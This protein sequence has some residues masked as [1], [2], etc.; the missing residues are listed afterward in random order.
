M[1][2]FNVEAM[3]HM[4]ANITTKLMRVWS[5]ST[6]LGVSSLCTLII[7]CDNIRATYHTF[8]LAFH[9]RTNVKVDYDFI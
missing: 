8:N 1:S 9:A 5:L 6:K 2:G 4:A 3:Y 7:H